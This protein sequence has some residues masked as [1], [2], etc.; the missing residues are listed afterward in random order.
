VVC[1]KGERPPLKHEAEV[2]ERAVGGKQLPVKGAV[3][4]LG[5]AE[6]PA[7]KPH[8]SPVTANPLLQDPADMGTRGVNS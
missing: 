8:G 1:K 3:V 5:G 2:A 6:L 7:E 4:G